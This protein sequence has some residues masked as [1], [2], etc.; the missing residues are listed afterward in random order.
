MCVYC[1]VMIYLTLP[2]KVSAGPLKYLE[3]KVSNTGGQPCQ[4]KLSPNKNSGHHGSSEFPQSA[5]FYVYSY[6]LLLGKD[7]PSQDSTGRGQMEIHPWSFPGLCPMCFSLANF[8]L[9]PSAV[10]AL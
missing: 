1:T 7:S 9:H 6:T 8:N 4:Y 5:L 2:Q 3:I 10:L